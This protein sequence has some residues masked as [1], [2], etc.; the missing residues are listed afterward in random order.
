MNKRTRTTLLS[1]LFSVVAQGLLFCALGVSGTALAEPKVGDK[2]QNPE[3][4]DARDQ[5]AKLPE[6]GN[7][8]LLVLYTDPDEADQND[9]FADAVKALGLNKTNFQ[10]MGVANMKDA[11]AKPNWIIRRV[12]RKKVEKYGT[13]ILTDPDRLL[14]TAWS[15]GDCNDKSVVMILDKEGTLRYFY[16]GKLPDG[17]RQ[18]ALDLLKSLVQ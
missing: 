15:L 14:A 1:S 11:P 5:P 4:R 6:W 17:E 18:K 13:T 16:K 10:S 2:L 7:K 3:V 12:V 9:A 8:V